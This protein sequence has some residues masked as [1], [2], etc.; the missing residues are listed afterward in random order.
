MAARKS[1]LE[2]LGII[3]WEGFRSNLLKHLAYDDQSRGGRPPWCPVLMLKVMILQRFHN[4]S[5]METEFQINDL[6]SIL[7]FVGLRP[8]DR[9][10]D[11]LTIWDFKEKL[12]EEGMRAIFEDFDAV[13]RAK[14]LVGNSGK[15][16]DASFV[17]APR[18]RNS[19]EENAEI[20]QGKRPESFDENP[21]RGCQKDSDAR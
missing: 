10:P 6:F 2:R 21:R 3:G 17:D 11:H 4:L 13:L 9:A 7:R 14:G 16:V 20:K 1:S 18:Q 19:R 5:D 8:G 12:G 15:I